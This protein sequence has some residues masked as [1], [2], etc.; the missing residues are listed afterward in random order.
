MMAKFK[1]KKCKSEKVFLKQTLVFIKGRF[2]VK[3]ARCKCGN[4]MEDIEQYKGFGTSFKADTD[5][6]K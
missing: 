4:Y 5:K 3:E 1:C 2:R 6:Y